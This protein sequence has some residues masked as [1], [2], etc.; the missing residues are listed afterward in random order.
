[1]RNAK[2]S[3]SN[4]KNQCFWSTC[5]QLYN[6]TVVKYCFYMTFDECV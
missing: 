4:R 5:K 1:M 6:K 2:K 3:K